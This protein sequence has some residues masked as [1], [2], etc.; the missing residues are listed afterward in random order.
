MSPK[1]MKAGVLLTSAMLVALSA[2]A[3][4]AGGNGAAVDEEGVKTAAATVEELSVQPMS[5]GLEEALKELPTGKVIYELEFPGPV[6]QVVG[7]AVVE[8]CDALGCKVVRVPMGSDPAATT[9]AWD[10]TVRDKPDAVVSA[11]VTTA[12]VGS[13]MKELRGLGIPVV[14][15]AS[16]AEVG[17]EA[18]AS[19][20]GT[21]RLAKDGALQADWIIADS[22]GK[23]KILAIDFPDLGF[24]K[25][26]ADGFKDEISRLCPACEVE[27]ENY[28]F[29]IA[30]QFPSRVVSFL[31]QNPDVTYIALTYGDQYIGLEQAL[32]A[33]GFADKVKIVGRGGTALNFQS[34]VDGGPQK[35]DIG[36]PFGLFSW[37][38]VDSAA[39]LLAGQEAP[40]PYD[41][42]TQVLTRDTIAFNPAEV[43][44]WLGVDDYKEQFEKSWGVD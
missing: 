12:L 38:L 3:E 4:E 28:G 30:E 43:P 42:I 41:S 21:D 39:R 6:G 9:A 8:A 7:D 19:F 15:Y 40:A 33:A 31:Q 37:G 1:S 17:V 36:Y 29:A 10:R 34:I 5:L 35:V 44:A 13:Q 16:E 24:V 11:G 2:C 14:V 25:P 20:G 26:W 32:R 22:D 18:D 27:T 23:A